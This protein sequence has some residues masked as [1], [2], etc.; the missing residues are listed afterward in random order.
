VSKTLKHTMTVE[1]EVEVEYEVSGSYVPARV[2][3]RAEDCH[4]AEHPEVDLV[5]VNVV[6]P[7]R[8]GIKRVIDI[9][10]ALSK[11]AEE[12]INDEVYDEA[13]RSQVDRKADHDED[14]ADAMRDERRGL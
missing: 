7:L 1:I 8:P 9:L 5:A 10:P 2:Y 11:D 14:R 6:L 13:C 3:G 12:A 4:P